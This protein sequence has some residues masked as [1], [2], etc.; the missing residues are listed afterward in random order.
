[1]GSFAGGHAW[2][3]PHQYLVVAPIGGQEVERDG[4]PSCRHVWVD[5]S[6][7]YLVVAPVGHVGMRE[8]APSSLPGGGPCR[9]PVGEAAW[10]SQRWTCLG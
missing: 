2:I 1:M 3:T 7:Q 8:F 5:P 9:Q 4:A 10:G 6:S